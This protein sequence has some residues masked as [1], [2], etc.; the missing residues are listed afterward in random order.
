MKTLTFKSGTELKHNELL[1]GVCFADDFAKQ[2]GCES[3]TVEFED[4]PKSTVL[5]FVGDGQR[6]KELSF[7][8]AVV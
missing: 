5:R 6:T 4:Q 2:T 1:S 7:P 8:K 3:V